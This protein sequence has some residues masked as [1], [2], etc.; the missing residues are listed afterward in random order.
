MIYLPYAIVIGI[1]FTQLSEQ[2]GAPPCSYF[3]SLIFQLKKPSCLRFPFIRYIPNCWLH[4]MACSVRG[5]R[6]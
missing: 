1:M 5:M 6:P 2:T 3:T 4:H